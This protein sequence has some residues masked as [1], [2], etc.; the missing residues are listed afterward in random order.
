MG[1][2]DYILLRA[3]VRGR[4]EFMK[5]GLRILVVVLLMAIIPIAA[6]LIQR[7]VFANQAPTASFIYSP[8]IPTPGETITF[9]AT[10]SN[11]PYG[12]IIRYSWDFG[13]GTTATVTNPI[14]TYAYPVDGTYTVQLTV[15]DTNN[16]TGVAS[17][18]IDISTVTFFRVCFSGSVIPIPNVK[19]TEY[20]YDGAAWVKAPTGPHGL[21]IKYD[22]TTPPGDKYRNPGYTA[23]KLED[24]ASNIGFDLHPSTWTVY[25][26]FEWSGQV[27]YWPNDTTRVYTYKDGAI[28][29]YDY[30][31]GH[32]AYYDSNAGTYVI[33][34]NNIPG[35]GVAPTDCHP[36]IVGV[37]CPPPIQKYYLT[38]KTDP[39]S[40]TTI[41]GQGWY[42]KGTNVTLTAP[43]YV[44]VSCDTRY[45]F[46]YWDVDGTSK[47]SGVNPIITCMNA[48][49]TATAHYIEQYLVAFHQ[50]GLS[51]DATGTVVVVDGSGKAYGD[52]P[53]SKWVNNGGTV[54]Y[55]F[56]STVSSSVSGNQY[57]L[58]SVTGSSSP[59]TVT[60]PVC[61][62]GCYTKQYSV[63]LAQTGLDST[64]TG[65]VVTVNGNAKAYGDLPY[66]LWVD[67]CSSVAYSYTSVVSSSGTGERFRLNSVSGPSSP[68]K[69]TGSTTVTGNYVIQYSV[70]FAQTGLDSTA[71]G[72]VVTVNGNTKALSDLPYTLWVDS[73]NTVTYSYS[74][75]VS[76]TTANKQFRL[77]GVTGSSSPITVTGATTVT[78]NYVVQYLLTFAQ[79]GLDST[80]MG[81]VVTVN[82]NAKGYGDLPYTMWADS[83]SSIAYSYTSVVSS[84]GT[85]ERFRLGSV[86]GSSSPITVTG[87]TTVTGN[88]VAQ[89][90]VTFSQAGLDSTATGTVV[91][92]N[93]N[94]KAYGDL[95]YVLW[96]DSGSSVAYSYNDPVLSTTT[97]ERFK[98]TGVSGASSPITVTSAVTIS[99]TYK[100]QFQVTFDQA[101]VGSDFTGSVVTIDTVGYNSGG[102]P[103]SFWWDSSSSHRFSYGSPLVVNASKQYTWSSTAGLT[104]LQ[105]GTLTITA[106][107][108]VTGNYVVGNSITFD[109]TGI[110]SDFKGTVIMIDSTSYSVTALP[111]SLIWQ[112]GTVHNFSFESAL[113]VAANS[114]QYVW[115]GTSG[116]SSS[117]SGSITVS[118]AGSVVGHYKTQ[119]YLTLATNPS[120]VNSPSGA[121]WYDASS[122]ASVTTASSVDIVSGSSRYSFVN[123][124]TTYTA[125]ITGP[126]SAT[127]TVLMDMAKTVTANYV[128]QYQVTFAQA[129]VGSDFTSSVVT[130]DGVDYS[131]SGLSASFWWDQNSQHTITWYS[132]LV[133]TANTEQYVWTSSTGLFTS[134]TGTMTVTTY[135]TVTGNYGTQYYLTVTSPYRTPGG[136]GWYNSGDTAYATLNSPII[137]HGNGTR[138]V[139]SGWSG[140]ASGTSFAQSSAISMT[141]AKT[142]VALWKT[143]YSLSFTETGLD[144]T[145]TGTVVTVNGFPEAYGSLPHV[146]WVD[147][148]S[149]VT[150]SY[151]NVSSTTTGERFILTGV[152]GPT[153]PI[154]VTT[155][156]SVIGNYKTQYKVTFNQ[157]AVSSDFAGTVVTVDSTGYTVAALPTDFWWDNGSSHTFTFAS[158]LAVSAG[159]EYD[160]SSTTGLSTSR[161]DT[162]TIFSSGNVTGNYV[163]QIRCQITFSQT[164]VGSDF[165]GTVVTIDG[166]YYNITSLPVSFWWN[167]GSLHWFIFASALSVNASKQYVWANTTGLSTSQAH[168]IIASS[169]GN[170]TGNY[171]TQYYLTLATSPSGV[172]PTGAG[173]YDDGASATISTDAFVDITS[174]SSRYRFNGWT[175]PDMSEIADPTRSPTTVRM[176][177]GKTV[178]A[179]YV[180]QY[181]VSFNQS[182][183]SSDFG[184]NVLTVDGVGYGVNSLPKNF[185]WDNSSVHTFTFNSPLAVAANSKQY[186]WTDTTGLST[187]QTGS[188]TVS[189]SGSVTGDYKT[190][191]HLT[192]SINPSGITTIPGQGWYDASTTSTLT[193]PSVSGYQFGYWDVDG[194]SQGTGV[195]PITVTMDAAHTA[196]AHYAQIGAQLTVTI[197]PL[198]AAVLPGNQV[199][200]SSTVTGGTSPYGY[201]WYLN[202]NPVSG[203]NSSTWTF[204]PL[205]QGIYYVY[206][207][208]TDALNS[209]GQSATARVVVIPVSVGGYSVSLTKA[210]W[211][212]LLCYATLLAMFIVAIGLIRRKRK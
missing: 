3:L 117:Q 67:S 12:S 152:A 142:A 38:V 116:L 112:S 80:A 11:D 59:I 102:L 181:H 167:A 28:E 26:K 191:Y 143:R 130:I 100:I 163:V 186:V 113:L 30:L 156:T 160:W 79:T 206:L 149:S 19:V 192:V 134:Q 45:Q 129:G 150:F 17:A 127:T 190:Q 133:V 91:T 89:Y 120:G 60:G 103:V 23:I 180:V 161:G 5:S 6:I 123:W 202:D 46:N 132:P 97:G 153:S 33:G 96:V 58:T 71:P 205:A 77:T 210:T 1:I 10:G 140:D 154:T 159:K 201:Q 198:S 124:T 35:H 122:Y 14:I 48:N 18:V 182:G 93:G 40:I 111:V 137:D 61:V 107:G 125:E 128:T 82:G 155:P 196:T 81:T 175:T 174:G 131:V 73:G 16:A 199:D 207:K 37:K 106:S 65:T 29:A 136:Q 178:T 66:V 22:S 108:S 21:E 90:S 172:D 109:Q 36:I 39:A 139:F 57:R 15:T 119:Y 51:S 187:S 162:L 165:T 188:I 170:I 183:V 84:S 31:P 25:F 141:A 62:T 52:L 50:S 177:K 195:N 135:G 69:V 98:Q 200:F 83:S 7:S 41:S 189:V 92:V 126:S 144:S 147:A 78:G 20:Y 47:G 115:T 148:G 194:T 203:A 173:W 104:T 114:K 121:G 68:I 169:S 185:W 211:P 179:N 208:V 164:G 88:Y 157:S 56:S 94:A 86:T 145:A 2:K 63:T 9:N 34:V 75:P 193:A 53:Y 49:H 4:R 44:N 27:A 158:P 212:L 101:G 70:T 138:H 72:T 171:K 151:S 209:I 74:S 166:T 42:T 54:T 146:I 85:G 76:S 24:G 204:I 99:G 184:G 95:S 32:Q 110:S 13:D 8:D 55:S 176:D 64:A 43:S 168:N 105:S 197:T 87:A 118:G